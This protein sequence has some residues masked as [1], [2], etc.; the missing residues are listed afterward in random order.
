MV[1]PG[2]GLRRRADACL[3]GHAPLER[4]HGLAG[5]DPLT[6]RAG[7]HRHTPSHTLW[8]LPSRA[9][10]V[11]RLSLSYCLRARQAVPLRGPLWMCPTIAP[12]AE[13]GT[14]ARMPAR[15]VCTSAHSPGLASPYAM[16]S[17]TPCP[18]PL[19][20]PTLCSGYQYPLQL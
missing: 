4:G 9:S 18:P 3:C 13:M 12:L 11:P 16:P 20:S 10:P 1:R 15:A 6:N 2:G 14:L 17:L 19:P 7:P 8:T 5:W